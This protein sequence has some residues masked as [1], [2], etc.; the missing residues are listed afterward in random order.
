LVINELAMNAV[1]YGKGQE[2]L[3]LS[4]E[5]FSLPERLRLVFRDNGPGFPQRILAGERDKFSIGL[6]LVGGIVRQSLR[7]TLTLANDGGAVVTIEFPW[8]QEEGE[9]ND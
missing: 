8:A 4:V 9:G 5:I 3:R 2:S 7:G 1:K 6:D